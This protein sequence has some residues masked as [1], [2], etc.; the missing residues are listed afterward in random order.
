MEHYILLILLILLLLLF[1]KNRKETFLINEE[2]WLDY[3]LGDIITGYFREKKQFYYLKKIDK[4]LP[5]SIGSVYIKKTNNLE[6]NLQYN[7][8]NILKDII[9]K[10][11][12]LIDLPKKDDLVIHLRIGDIIRGSKNNIKF[13]NNFWY[14][15]DISKLDNTLNEIKKNIKFNK[16]YLV[17]GSHDKD[18]SLHLNNKYLD[19][20]KKILKKNNIIPILR[21]T[22]P[23][24]DFIFMSQSKYFVRSG[25]GFSN[26][27]S[28]LVKK[29]KGI[30]Y[31]PK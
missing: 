6:K 17:Y 8:F 7:N 27:I 15:T 22:N 10:K 23:D 29:N 28:E 12:H 25:G 5:N 3:R 4:N 19:N 30:V 21:N 26:I 11:K 20:V 24:D 31:I 18:I 1:L 2:K 9:N 13:K 14:G 16:V